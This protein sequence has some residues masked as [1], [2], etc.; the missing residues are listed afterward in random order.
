MTATATNH[1]AQTVMSVEPVEDRLN[2]ILKMVGLL[3]DL[4]FLRNPT[5]PGR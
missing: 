3:E 4:T 2:G 5:R 1:Q